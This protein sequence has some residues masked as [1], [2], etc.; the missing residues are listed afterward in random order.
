MNLELVKSLAAD[1][2]AAKGWTI[3]RYIDAGASGAVFEIE[4]PDYGATALKVYDPKFFEGEDAVIEIKRVALQADLMDHG[5]EHLVEIFEVGD[6][7]EGATHYLIME[8]CPWPS[9]EKRLAELPDDRVQELLRQLVEAV[10]F[11]DG[12]RLVHRDI[13]P[14][15]IAIAPDY[16]RL[17]LLDLGVL[18]KMGPTEGAGTDINEKK[19]FVAT[20][21]YSP[22]EYLA[23][24][25]AGGDDGFE[26]LNVY[27]IGAVLHDMIMKRPLFAEAAETNNRYVLFKA[28]SFTRPTLFNPNLPAR[29]IS[30]CRAALQKDPVKRLAGV[31]LS[32]LAQP[33]DSADAVRRRLS[34]QRP[35]PDNDPKTP[36]L[37][38]WTGKVS[39]W[40]RSA[41][42]LEKVVLGPHHLKDIGSVGVTWKLS[43]PAIQRE[44]C[45][46]LRPADDGPY[47]MLVVAG[48]GAAE[49]SPLLEIFEAGPGLERADIVGQLREQI[50]FALDAAENGGDSEEATD[51]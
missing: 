48:D 30:L 28:I 11:L 50:I 6:F 24:E 23:R 15:N 39:A 44:I 27:Q 35:A 47:L 12:R 42:S 17:K 31:K 26:A 2:A 25:E 4:H 40:I 32:D 19:R 46:R 45:L 16:S 8:L 49:G 29:L 9:L 5:N 21:Q 10:S 3:I 41:M 36:S 34:A 18:R 20:A 14:A 7:P 22:P 51:E 13:K 1:L 37:R 38:L 33:I 43:F